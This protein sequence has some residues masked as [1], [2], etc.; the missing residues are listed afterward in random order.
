MKHPVS[1]LLAILLLFSLCGCSGKN[2]PTVHS[3]APSFSATSSISV[4]KSTEDKVSSVT[5]DEYPEQLSTDELEPNKNYTYPGFLLVKENEAVNKIYNEPESHKER[6]SVKLHT[7]SKDIEFGE[8]I[9]ENL[10]EYFNSA[11]VLKEGEIPTNSSGVSVFDSPTSGYYIFSFATDDYCYSQN[12]KT[13]YHKQSNK[14]LKLSEKE[15]QFVIG[16]ANYYPYNYYY[17]SFEDGILTIENKFTAKS[18]LQI[19]VKDIYA[20]GNEN[21]NYVKLELVSEVS[22]K[23][24]VKL[25]CDPYGGEDDFT[26]SQE[27]KLKANKPYEIKMEFPECWNFKIT[28][29]NTVINIYMEY[30]SFTTKQHLKVALKENP[31][32]VHP[33]F[34]LDMS[35]NVP[36]NKVYKVNDDENRTLNNWKVEITKREHMRTSTRRVGGEIGDDF[37]RLLKSATILSDGTAPDYE[38]LPY[39]AYIFKTKTDSYYIDPETHTLYHNEGKTILEMSNEF[40]Q[41]L[42]DIWYYYPTNSYYGRY[43]DGVLS[44]EHK[45]KAETSVDIRVK[46][47]YALGNGRFLDDQKNYAVFEVS[48]KEDKVVTVGASC[49]ASDDCIGSAENRKL[50]LKANKPQEVI[51]WFQYGHIWRVSAGNNSIEIVVDFND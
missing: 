26:N 50:F 1:L 15:E 45:Y 40:S 29:D 28:G 30:G 35:N 41:L 21:N 44:L 3:A 4:S 19:E 12:D 43:E 27:V 37:V 6:A 10:L 33:Q 13:V 42:T 49:V 39:G 31:D 51:L 17:G 2:D 7:I 24:Q 36:T 20:P 11:T 8:E 22:Q 48:S 47:I 18:D 5:A 16:L 32:Y 23:F 34:R 46:D 38:H 9:A 14:L 25:E